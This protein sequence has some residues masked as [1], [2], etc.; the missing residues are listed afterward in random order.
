MKWKCIM[1]NQ[2]RKINHVK[3]SH[4]KQSRFQRITSCEL[5]IQVRTRQKW[6][7][8]TLTLLQSHHQT[9]WIKKTPRSIYTIWWWHQ[10]KRRKWTKYSIIL[11][12]ILISTLQGMSPS[13]CIHRPRLVFVFI[14]SDDDFAIKLKYYIQSHFCLVLT[15]MLSSQDVTFWNLFCFIFLQEWS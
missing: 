9:E 11:Y 10:M 5:K 12:N 6:D 15:Q 8:N 7:C 1:N 13:Y 4:I 2:K 14:L 3:W